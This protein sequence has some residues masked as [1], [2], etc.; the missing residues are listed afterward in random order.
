MFGMSLGELV[1]IFVVAFVV[2]GPERLPHIAS[3]IGKM[4]AD[5]KRTSDSFRREFY[6]AV[7]TPANELK[8][9]EKDL[10][11]LV[12]DNSPGTEPEKREPAKTE[13][14]TTDEPAR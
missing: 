6:N 7:Y 13:I 8:S 12:I 10:G 1:V 4:T 9:L 14:S 3:K 11:R 5:L 2:F